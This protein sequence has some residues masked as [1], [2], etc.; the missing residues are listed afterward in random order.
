[1]RSLEFKSITGVRRF[2]FVPIAVLLAALLSAPAV[3]RTSAAQTITA[4]LAQGP[5]KLDGT[6]SPSE[7]TDAQVV[8]ITTAGM[9]VAFK[10]N[11]TGLFMLFQWKQSANMCSDQ[12]CY[13]GIEIDFLN[14]TGV[15]GS[16][17]TP[18]VMPLLS[19]SF[20]GGVDE[21]ISK[22]MSTPVPVESSGYKTQST[23]ALQLSGTMYTGE[24]YRPFKLSNA[25]PYDPFPALVAGTPIEIGF[26]V[27]EFNK[28][29]V[30]AATT[31]SSYVLT[32]SDQ[33]Y[34]T[35]PTTTQ[36]STTTTATTPTSANTTATTATSP[37]TSTT[38]TTST[39]PTSATTTQAGPSVLYYSSELAVIV[40]GFGVF[41]LAAMWRY[42]KG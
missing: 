27:G 1:L 5:V 32:L 33:T 4:N 22:T 36:T 31:M 39:I 41:V 14:N 37:T 24:C 42:R 28:P 34:G 29:G 12:Y 40:A 17:A 16:S 21:F 8:N 20:S 2:G 10:H 30:H 15:M 25:S 35:G 3:Q 13:G 19:P 7:W 23:C 18:A 9:G 38:A 26:A 11:A 6:V